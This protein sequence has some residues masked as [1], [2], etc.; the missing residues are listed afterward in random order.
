MC[1]TCRIEIHTTFEN[2]ANLQESVIHCLDS[3]QHNGDPENHFDSK[4][5]IKASGLLR[6]LQVSLY[7]LKLVITYM[8]TQKVCQSN[9]QASEIEIIKADEMVSLVVEQPCCA[10]P[11]KKF[12]KRTRLDRISVLRRVCW[13]RG[14]GFFSGRVAVFK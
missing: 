1:E 12:L 3:L 14:G 6:Q 9:F 4:I 13:E 8:V 2:L 10:P 5:V 7:H 11:L